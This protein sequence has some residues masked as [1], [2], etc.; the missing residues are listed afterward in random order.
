MKSIKII[1]K[2][3]IDGLTNKNKE[4]KRKNIE[5]LKKEEKEKLNDTS[6][7][8]LLNKLYLEQ[9]YSGVK[10]MKQEVNRKLLSYKNQDIKT[11]L[12]KKNLLHMKNVWKN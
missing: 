1:G 9:E 7:V 11:S 2:R 10:F 4:T 8:E 6:Q 12:T 3:N 5:N